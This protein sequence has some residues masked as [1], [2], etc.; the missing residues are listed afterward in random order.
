MARGTS[1]TDAGLVSKEIL[2]REWVQRKLGG[3]AHERRVARKAEIFFQ[4]TWRWH[5]L[6]RADCR[7]LTLAALVHDVGRAEG[8]DAHEKSGAR[9]LMEN[10][11]LPLTEA[12]RRRLAFMTRHHR[13]RVPEVGAERYLNCNFDDL[14]VMRTLLGLL[15]AADSLDSRS[16]GGPQIVA[17]VYGKVI[18]IYGYVAG[19]A[20]VAAATLGKPKKFRLLES[21]LGCQVRTQWFSTDRLALV[22]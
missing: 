8:D 15:R 21:T 7:L 19:D 6:G 17:T 5:E 16:Q 2:V 14:R 1:I 10:T 11:S 22:S 18:T 4:L 13:G 3:V 20:A 9:M 12:E